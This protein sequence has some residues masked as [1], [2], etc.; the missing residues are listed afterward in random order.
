MN[1]E[2]GKLRGAEIEYREGTLEFDVDSVEIKAEAD[3]CCKGSFRMFAH[4][5]VR[6]EGK[7]YTTDCRMN[8]SDKGFRGVDMEVP[9]LYDTKG[10]ESGDIIQGEFYIVSNLGEYYLPYEVK[11]M[12]KTMDSELGEIKN[13]FH[14]ANLAKV[15]RQE[16]LKC[17]VSD[18]F[19]HILTGSGKQYREAYRGL[20]ENAIENQC[21]DYAME[22]FL[23]LIRKKQPVVFRWL[24][25]KIKYDVENVPDKIELVVERNGWGYTELSI[26]TTGAFL[27]E[28]HITLQEE[29]FSNDRAKIMINID[30]KKC[31]EGRNR[32]L[33]RMIGRDCKKQCEI[34]V[35]KSFENEEKKAYQFH[36]RQLTSV[37][38]RLYLDYRAGTKSAKECLSLA[39]DILER[40]QSSGEL[41]PILYFAHVKLLVGQENEAIWLLKQAKRLMEGMEMPLDKYGYF[42][43]L[44]AM[45]ESDDRKRA[46]ELL[47]RYV[48]QYPDSFVLYWGYMHKENAAEHNPGTVYRR[49][50]EF[51]ENGCN[52]PVLY[53]EAAM[54]VLKN[55]TVYT[56]MDGFEVQLLLFMERYDLLADRICEQIY[57]AATG[58]KGYQP[59]LIKVLSKHPIKDKKKML[60]ILC[61]QYMR[62]T[63]VGREAAEVLRA[64]IEAECRITGIYEAYIR[65]L[66]DNLGEVLPPSVVRYFAY[67]S[68]LNDAHL[69]YVYAKIIRQQEDI[70]EE[71][72]KKIHDFTMRQLR[73]G[74]I[75]TNLA[76]LYRNILVP[77]DM[78][79]L[80]QRNL[81]EL[82]FVHVLTIGDAAWQN[83]II[84][85]EG[86]KG[87]S[88]YAIKNG[89]AMIRIYSDRYTV[90]FEDEKGNCRCAE[91]GYEVSPLLGY[92]RMKPL[93]NGFDHTAFHEAFYHFCAKPLE[94]ID[95]IHEFRSL[96]VQYRWLIQQDELTDA[97]RRQLAGSLLYAYGKWGLKEELDEFLEQADAD[98]FHGKDRGE[99]VHLLCEQGFYQNAF[100]TACNYGYEK[101]DDRVLARL[102]QFMIEEKDGAMDRD[103]LKLAYRVFERGK[104]TESMLEYLVCWFE[105]TVKQMRKVW[106]AAVSMEVG[107]TAIA[108]RILRQILLTGAYISDREKIF[109]YY[110]ERQG[111]SDLICTYLSMR[112]IE[113]L[114][115]DESVEDSV[116]ERLQ[117]LLMEH[118][119]IPLGAKLAFLKYHSEDV[120]ALT[121]NE[122]ALCAQLLGESLGADIYFPCYGSYT[123]IYPVLEVYGESGYIEFKTK[124]GVRVTVNYII[125]SPK[126]LGTAYCK[127]DLQEVYPGIYQK[128]FRLFWGERLQYYVTQQLG[129][130]EQFVMSG[131]MERGETMDENS[132]G[133]FRM[134]NDIAL[135]VELRDYHTAETLIQEY[136]QHDFMT[137]KMLRIK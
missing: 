71:Y 53:M 101:T 38:M 135:S 108:E 17:F 55:P 61:M 2:I 122:K 85:H 56:V 50:K 94:Q 93:L 12:G 30:V 99:Y 116:F 52:N 72:D 105:G 75:D 24:D 43:Y 44:T 40:M 58:V 109:S 111:S 26:E 127:E 78:D 35:E 5:S 6:A 133:R 41:M 19:I 68:S 1:S 126:G 18:E 46:E 92:E 45:S 128:A 27:K 57:H 21:V 39:G 124:P 95:N 62:G 37:M 120:G 76:Y 67:D 64:G 125:D 13:L 114:V 47:D 87:Q 32:G 129:E 110:C 4:A 23:V 73:A 28:C 34:I 121:D 51:W 130:E 31:K 25:E 10:L 74:R 22:Q 11:I 104:Y 65:A 20:V 117:P 134:L 115:H 69:A 96:E 81:Q 77:E 112:A 70:S 107:A 119:E 16:A 137:S 88:K 102:C 100:D 91:Q 29:D 113:Y 89:K 59:I 42:L 8:C 54:L 7:I 80:M 49:L 123:D 98:D 84:R 86:M 15:N 14:F 90:L 136:A 106:K 79:E 97:Y 48:E 3:T 63:C 132:Q 131:S 82:C 33:V 60:Q 83:C 103:V 9:F 118:K 36:K 66:N